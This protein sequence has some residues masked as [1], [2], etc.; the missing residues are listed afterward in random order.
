MPLKGIDKHKLPDAL[1]KKLEEK[2]YTMQELK[3]ELGVKNRKHIKKH[4]DQLRK[5]NK[6]KQKF[7]PKDE[8]MKYKV[9]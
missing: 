5:Q 8:T 3:N 9:I 7:D 2:E 6:M 4:I 1:K